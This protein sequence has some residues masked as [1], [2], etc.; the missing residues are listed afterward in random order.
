[1]VWKSCSENPAFPQTEVGQSVLKIYTFY[2]SSEN[3]M[4]CNWVIPFSV[5]HRPPPSPVSSL[6][7]KA[8]TPSSV[9]AAHKLIDVR[10][11]LEHEANHAAYQEPQ[12]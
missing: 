7:K 1:M 6:F 9:C 11:P 12:P 3:F 5:S 8:N 10:P 4:Q 2:H